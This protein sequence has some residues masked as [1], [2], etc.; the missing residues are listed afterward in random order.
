MRNIIYCFIFSLYI[1]FSSGCMEPGISWTWN[2]YQASMKPSL[3]YW[4][5]DG[6]TKEQRRNDA[7]ACGSTRMIIAPQSPCI[8]QKRSCEDHLDNMPNFFGQI[9]KAK[10]P[11][12]TEYETEKRLYNNWENCMIKKGYTYERTK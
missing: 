1:V 11:Y 6:A 12:E 8:I 4:R 5:K 7:V 3:Y 10:K 2:K 9:E